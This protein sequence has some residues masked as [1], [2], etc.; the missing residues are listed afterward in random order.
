M[1]PPTPASVMSP[2]SGRSN[3][4][5]PAMTSP[6]T[7]SK[8][9]KPMNAGLGH[10]PA[11]GIVR[12]SYGAY[13]HVTPSPPTLMYPHHMAHN[14]NGMQHSPSGSP[15]GQPVWMP[16]GPPM[17]QQGPP[18]MRGQQG[19]AYNPALMPYHTQNGAQN[20]MYPPP[21]HPSSQTQGGGYPGMSPSQMM[22][23][24]VM[25]HAAPVPPHMMYGASPVLLPIPAPGA[26][27]NSQAYPGAVGMGRAAIPTRNASDSRPTQTSAHNAGNINASRFNG[28]PYNQIPPQPFARTW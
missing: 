3:L 5:T 25:T 22:V 27:P 12:P 1:V 13:P 23:S 6:M 21:P 9:L 7:A 15:Y 8:P 26:P 14:H 16:M 18:M 11:N 28:P 17:H 19:S 2:A 4:F 24:P 20:G 10:P